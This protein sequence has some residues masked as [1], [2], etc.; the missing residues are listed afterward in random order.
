MVSWFRN[1][2]RRTIYRT[3]L[4]WRDIGLIEEFEKQQ[5]ITKIHDE[6]PFDV[7]VA[8]GTFFAT[9]FLDIGN[10]V[11]IYT[12]DH[13]RDLTACDDDVDP[14][15]YVET[16]SSATVICVHGR[17]NSIIHENEPSA[18]CCKVTTRE[19]TVNE[20]GSVMVPVKKDELL[21]TQND[22]ERIEKLG[23]LAQYEQ[24]SPAATHTMSIIVIANGMIDAFVQYCV[25][26]LGPNS[27]CA[28]HTKQSEHK[29]PSDKSASQIKFLSRFH[30]PLSGKH[31]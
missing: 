27:Q 11:D 24:P 25:Y 7:L 23:H 28:Y 30:E 31:G 21:F 17:M 16:K 20:N 2:I 10:R 4:W 12:K 18:G 8:D 19:P 13:L 22:K 6:R 3:S 15:G 9:L 5:E 29:V 1:T 14:F 26:E